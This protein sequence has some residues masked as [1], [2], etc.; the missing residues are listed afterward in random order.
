MF[1]PGIHHAYGP[2]TAPIPTILGTPPG[3][4]APPI[5]QAV[6][7]GIHVTAQRNGADVFIGDLKP[8]I[9]YSV[10]KAPSIPTAGGSC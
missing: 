4:F 5:P 8:Q 2:Y 9:D 6:P 1:A 3:E 7:G 10:M